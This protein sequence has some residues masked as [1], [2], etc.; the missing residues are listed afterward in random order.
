MGSLQRLSCNWEQ[1]SSLGRNWLKVLKTSWTAVYVEEIWYHKKRGQGNQCQTPGV[2]FEGLTGWKR[3][4]MGRNWKKK[5]ETEKLKKKQDQ[6]STPW[7]TFCLLCWFFF[8]PIW[9]NFFGENMCFYEKHVFLEIFFFVKNCLLGEI[10][11]FCCKNM[12]R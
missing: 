1:S 11:F 5:E 3:G 4:K 9:S 6:R 8:Y 10:M 12:F 2:K 7:P